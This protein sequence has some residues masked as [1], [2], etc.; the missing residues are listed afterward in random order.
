MGTRS[1]EDTRCPGRDSRRVVQL[2]RRLSERLV[3]GLVLR[4]VE[5]GGVRLPDIRPGWSQDGPLVLSFDIG[6]DDRRREEDRVSTLGLHSR[7]PITVLV[8]SCQD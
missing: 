3:T 5:P 4:V 8:L 1:P 6:R 7:V 2:L